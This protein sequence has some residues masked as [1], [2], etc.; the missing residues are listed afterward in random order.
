MMPDTEERLRDVLD[1]VARQ[2]RLDTRGYQRTQ[3]AWRRRER[4]RRLVATFIATIIIATAGIVGLWALN[5][6]DSSE[7]VIFDGPQPDPTSLV[8]RVPPGS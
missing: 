5:R 1:A 4:R 6:G 8:V 7:P 3:A 2:V